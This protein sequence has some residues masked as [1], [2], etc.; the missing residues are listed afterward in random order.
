M[1]TL[2]ALPTELL[3]IIFAELDTDALL[4]FVLVSRTFNELSTPSLYHCVYFCHKLSG[5]KEGC[6]FSR[7]SSPNS[8]SVQGSRMTRIYRID[9]FSSDAV[10]A[11][12]NSF[13][14]RG[15][16]SDAYRLELLTY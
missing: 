12:G 16:F 2:A 6:G 11:R 14:F 1:G 8:D 7:S 10:E 15:S 3:L 4:N 9:I 13:H 5:T